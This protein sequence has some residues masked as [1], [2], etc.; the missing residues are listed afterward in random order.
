MEQEIEIS[1]VDLK[2]LRAII[3][4]KLRTVVKYNRDIENRLKEMNKRNNDISMKTVK[5]ELS[6]NSLI[7]KILKLMRNINEAKIDKNI[8]LFIESELEK[9]NNEADKLIL[10]A[11]ENS[12]KLE[13]MGY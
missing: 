5:L 1:V 4:N 12:S 7:N 11:R 10:E 9:I 3:T 6:V 13:E 2:C 8:Y